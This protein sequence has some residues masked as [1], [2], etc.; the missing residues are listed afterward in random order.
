M[1]HSKM[2]LDE[3]RAARPVW[4]DPGDPISIP[5][6]VERFVQLAWR[7]G[8]GETPAV[9]AISELSEVDLSLCVVVGGTWLKSAD[10][11]GAH[12]FADAAAREHLH[13]VRRFRD[14]AAAALTWLEKL[15]RGSRYYL[16]ARLQCPKGK[17]LAN[18]YCLPKDSPPVH[19]S[20]GLRLLIA[21]TRRGQVT[22]LG[23]DGTVGTRWARAAHAW[24][25]ISDDDLWDLRCRCCP[26]PDG[27]VR[28]RDF[29]SN[30]T[31]H[32]YNA[33]LL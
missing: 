10:P 1:T 19:D 8:Y 25:Y 28:A 26:R 15:P 31:R 24:W 4:L 22:S 23:V 20:G 27:G 18:L 29:L 16:V 13:R 14:A 11:D 9:T 30:D 17:Q 3:L 33:V 6:A 5:D 21:P 2:T 12:A 32:G 7:C